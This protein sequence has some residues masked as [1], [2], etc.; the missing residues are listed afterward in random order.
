MY[1]RDYILR[2]IEETARFI[3]KI[4]GLLKEEKYD[5]AE[6]WLLKGYDLLHA[7]R[8]KLLHSDPSD[9]VMEL[10]KKQGYD[11]TRMELVADLIA[12]EGEILSFK[13]E[14]GARNM[15]L[16]ALAI[17]E[18]IELNHTIYSFERTDK[19]ARMK[20]ELGRCEG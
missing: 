8:D 10:E 19:I 12:M 4:L 9:I 3:A 5:E 2:L 14:P 16:K 11:L 15:R 18:Y 13:K 20:E 6:K 17:Y 7:D 1:R